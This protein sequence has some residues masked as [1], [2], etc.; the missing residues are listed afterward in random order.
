MAVGGFGE[1]QVQDG[2]R[3]VGADEGGETRFRAV[4]GIVAGVSVILVRAVGGNGG[5]LRGERSAGCRIFKTS[6]GLGAVAAHHRYAAQGRE[7]L[8]VAVAL[9]GFKRNSGAQCAPFAGSDGEITDFGRNVAVEHREGDV[10]KLEHVFPRVGGFVE[11]EMERT[12]FFSTEYQRVG[13]L[14]RVE[15]V[16]MRGQFA[17]HGGGTLRFAE[18]HGEAFGIVL[19]TDAEGVRELV[20]LTFL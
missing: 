13:L 16:G 15:D 5:V 4:A 14:L 10:V 6:H 12:V 1:L 3:D 9:R 7:R 8:S 18:M 17:R 19:L 11:A 20:F 2:V